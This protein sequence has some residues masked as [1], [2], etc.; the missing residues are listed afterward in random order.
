[1]RVLATM[2]LPVL[3]PWQQALA[4]EPSQA[5]CWG[6]GLAWAWERV[7]EPGLAPLA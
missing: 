2:G 6:Q 4:L 3:A 5:P 1:M 7:P